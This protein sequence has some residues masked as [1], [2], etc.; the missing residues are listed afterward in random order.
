MSRQGLK[1]IFRSMKSRNFRLFF[2]GQSISLIGT[3][4]QRMTIPWLVY[5]LTGSPFLLGLV[6][7]FGQFPTFMIAPFAGVLIDRWSRYHI[8]VISQVFAMFQALLLAFLYYNG[9]MEIWAIAAL[10]IL[11]GCIN[12]FDITAR[13][14]FVIELVE[15]KEDLAN[16]IALN[17]S[18]VNGAR[19]LGPSIAGVLIASV[20][21]GVCFLLNGI[22]YFFVIL[23]LVSLKLNSP[24]VIAKKSD[25]LKSLREGFAYTFGFSPLR[26]II[27]LIA[28]VSLA[29]MPYVV[30]MPIFAKEVFHGDSNTFGF[31]MGASGVGSL[32]GTVYLAS[33]TS[34]LGL[35]RIVPLAAAIFG[36][37]LVAFSLSR[38]FMVSAV[39]MVIIGFGM[40]L[41]MASSNT[42]IQTIVDDDKRGRVMSIYLMAFMGAVPIGSFIAGSL[43]GMIGPAETLRCGGI[44]C[45]L[46]AAV[47]ACRLSVLRVHVPETSI[48]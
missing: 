3:W 45:I 36:F 20:G 46:G 35:G 17:S 42:I 5:R 7:F 26:A 33:R 10:G 1:N 27:L 32:A 11:L 28:L 12:A 48:Y 30:L 13:Q 8:L 22:S 29:G 23:S 47:F 34:V 31:L 2:V 19:L 41:Q 25:V 18:M 15:N 6:S 39:L 44:I 37:G 21:E 40:M 38:N 43:S 4:I 24:A 16:A 14:A 9:P